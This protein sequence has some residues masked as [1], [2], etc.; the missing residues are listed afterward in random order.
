MIGVPRKAVRCWAFGQ[1]A[2]HVALVDEIATTTFSI[3][4]TWVCHRQQMDNVG[5]LIDEFDFSDETVFISA[6]F[7]ISSPR[8]LLPLMNPEDVAQ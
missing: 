8:L 3:R 1:P 6:G 7:V 5:P 2:W 4:M